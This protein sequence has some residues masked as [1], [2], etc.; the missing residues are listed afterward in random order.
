[1]LVRFRKKSRSISATIQDPDHVA[2]PKEWSDESL[3]G[4]RGV[5]PQS[6]RIVLKIRRPL[7]LNLLFPLTS[8][9]FPVVTYKTS[10]TSLSDASRCPRYVHGCFRS[11]FV[12]LVRAG[13]V[14][15]QC[16]SCAIHAGVAQ[17][18][19]HGDAVNMHN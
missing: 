14:L 10:R 11:V 4:S 7:S 19:H 18:D 9:L 17:I 8:G 2:F 15:L 13:T 16:R 12:A 3:N 1:M 5:T 6:K